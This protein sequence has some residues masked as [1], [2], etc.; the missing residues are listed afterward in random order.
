MPP[1]KPIPTVSL[2]LLANYGALITAAVAGV[3]FAWTRRPKTVNGARTDAGAF[4][5]ASVDVELDQ[6]TDQRAARAF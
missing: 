1:A 2:G 5:G 3:A 4:A 6:R